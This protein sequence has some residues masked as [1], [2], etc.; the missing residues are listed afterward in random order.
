MS[1]VLLSPALPTL[2]N[3]EDVKAFI[4]SE[5]EKAVNPLKQENKR[6]GNY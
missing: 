1:A 2:A 3:L 6:L 4:Q 5:I